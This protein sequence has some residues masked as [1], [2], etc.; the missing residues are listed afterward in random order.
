MIAE[1]L[2]VG[3]ELASGERL[4]TNSQWL[5]KRLAD[6]GIA[7]VYHTTVADDL[8]ANVEVFRTA[9]R[10][11]DL[12][13]ST[14]GLGP[15]ADDLTREAA[16]L[17][18]ER[19][20]E[21]D[22][23]A[24]QAIRDLF[25]RRGRE[26]PER[27]AVQADFPQG[28]LV[29][30]NPHGSAPGF[31]LSLDRADRSAAH[32]F[33]LPGVPAEMKQMWEQTVQP[34]IF[35]LL[36]NG[37][38][39]I[40]HRTLHCFGLGESDVEAKLPNLIQRGRSP[41]VGIT[42]SQAT[43]T[44]RITASGSDENECR[45]AIQPVEQIIRDCLGELVFGVEGQTLADVVVEQLRQRG[46][47]LAIADYITGGRLA[48]MLADADPQSRVYLGGSVGGSASFAAAETRAAE[49]A[50]EHYATWGL[51][52]TGPTPPT[53]ESPLPRIR[54]AVTQGNHCV[55]ETPAF[56]AHPDLILARAA[57]QGL[58]LLRRVLRMI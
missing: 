14:G 13:I 36:G 17:A 49:I 55:A 6:L 16:A 3:D 52:L 44:L 30:P 9:M 24:L 11:A 27:N 39:K 51:A 48:V 37:R 21:R 18:F 15:T 1:V 35:D 53:S 45:T 47:N 41:S 56:A 57:K 32:F 2:A 34:R 5:A 46:E 42:A 58:D 7:T 43:I 4:D 38:R 28:S 54:I 26:M 25:Q 33:A 31:Q 50:R 12:V 10:R 19:P 20:L 40:L 22:A 8:A 29:I 23:V